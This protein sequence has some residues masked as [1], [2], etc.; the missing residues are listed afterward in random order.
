MTRDLG[1][2]AVGDHVD[3]LGAG[4]ND[5]GLLGIAADHEAVD[6]LQENERHA[7]L[8]AI[9]DEAGGLV[10]GV[11]VNDA[12]ELQASRWAAS[13]ACRWLATTPTGHAAQPAV[14]ADERLAK[15]GLVFIEGRFIEKAW[16]ADR[17]HR[18][19]DAVLEPAKSSRL[20]RPG[21]PAG[22]IEVDASDCRPASVSTKTPQPFEAGRF[23]RFAEVDGAADR[24][25]HGRAAQ[26]FVADRLADG[27]LHQRRAGKVQAAAFGH[28]QFVAQDGQIAAAGHAIAQDGR[29]LRNARRG[30]D[31]VVAKDAAEIILVGKDL[32]LQRQ[33]DAGAID[34]IKQRQAIF[35]GDALGPQ[36]LLGRHRKEGARL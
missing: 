6:V 20:R 2:H 24:G 16:R 29:E 8:I 18:I 23:I 25:M 36:H 35:Q 28:E 32:V 31:G 21:P 33:K 4:A 12:A 14:A 1:H 5:A 9:H 27:R 19:R 17:A 7:A 22:T 3:Q 15:L 26:V 11:D 13:R 10:G 30:D 34:E